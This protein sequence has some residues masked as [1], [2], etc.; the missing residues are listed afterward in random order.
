M[1][2]VVTV[3]GFVSMA[4]RHS[5]SLRRCQFVVTVKTLFKDAIGETRASLGSAVGISYTIRSRWPLAAAVI[6]SV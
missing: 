4:V 3:E 5:L 1:P 2:V 6:Q